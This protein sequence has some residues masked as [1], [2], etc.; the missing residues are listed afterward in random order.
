MSLYLHFMISEL[1][2]LIHLHSQTFYYTHI[3][4]YKKR[5]NTFKINYK[6]NSIPTFLIKVFFLKNCNKYKWLLCTLNNCMVYSITQVKGIYLGN[7]CRRPKVANKSR[8]KF[9][10]I[11]SSFDI[12]S[13]F[14][15]IPKKII[16]HL[17]M[18]YQLQWVM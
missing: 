6:L 10:L 12:F 15:K 2:I 3:L 1:C 9:I 5:W 4:F 7:V 8:N 17:T 18:Q 13:H 14:F 11:T 16:S